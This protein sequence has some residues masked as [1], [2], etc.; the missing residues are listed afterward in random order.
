MISIDHKPLFEIRQ[1]P[2]LNVAVARIEKRSNIDFGNPRN[3]A[4]ESAKMAILEK[5]PGGLS[6]GSST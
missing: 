4:K 5:S 6:G 3:S 2:K 1:L